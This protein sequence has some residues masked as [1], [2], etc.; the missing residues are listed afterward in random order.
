MKLVANECVQCRRP[1]GYITPEA[2]AIPTMCILCAADPETMKEW[3][4]KIDGHEK[5]I[6]DVLLDYR[7]N[8]SR[9]QLKPPAP[10]PQNR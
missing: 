1:V 6:N 2:I 10:I 5:P 4:H 7:W 8:L 9:M 3:G